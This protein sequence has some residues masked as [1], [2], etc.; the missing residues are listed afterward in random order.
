MR[1]VK[2]GVIGRGCRGWGLMD[3]MGL[4]DMYEFVII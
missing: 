2:I 3:T 1:K 4:T